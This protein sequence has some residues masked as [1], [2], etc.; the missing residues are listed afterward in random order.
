[1]FL[2]IGTALKNAK[3]PE[4]RKLIVEERLGICHP[5]KSMSSSYQIFP[6]H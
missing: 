3:S 2:A 5:E 1:M 6:F 4:E